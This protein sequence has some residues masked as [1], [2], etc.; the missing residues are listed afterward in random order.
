MTEEGAGTTERDQGLRQRNHPT[1]SRPRPSG[2]CRTSWTFRPWSGAS[3]TSGRS[4]AR[5]TS[6]APRTPT[7]RAGH[8]STVPSRPTTPWACITPGAAPT[9]TSTSATAPCAATTSVIRTASTAR[10]YGLRSKSKKSSGSSPSATSR[11]SGSRPLPRP[12]ASGSPP[13]PRSRPRS[14]R[15]WGSGWIGTTPT[16]PTPT[17]TSS[18]SGASCGAATSAAGSRWRSAP[19]PGARA[20]ARR[21]RSTS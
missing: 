21:S 15:A 20:A 6:C 7:A 5:S 18:T 9:R 2:R 12:A 11:P 1:P 4:R 19:C 10:G 14:P 8:S 3:W 17:A 13:I 16:T